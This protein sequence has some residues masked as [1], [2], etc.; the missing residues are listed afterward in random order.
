[1]T[2]I[3][4]GDLA[5]LANQ[6]KGLEICVAELDSDGFIAYSTAEPF[7]CL[8]RASLEDLKGAVSGALS[9]YISTFYHIDMASVSVASEDIPSVAHKVP[10]EKANSISRLR[11]IFDSFGCSESHL[12]MV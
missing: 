12:A 4:K 7:F 3:Q 9:S 5:F 8:E 10:V 1:M 2:H 11:P 6:L